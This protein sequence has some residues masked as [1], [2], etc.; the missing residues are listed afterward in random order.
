MLSN[1][2]RLLLALEKVKKRPSITDPQLAGAVEEAGALICAG[3][4]EEVIKTAD[5]GRHEDT[6]AQI[7]SAGSYLAVAFK[8]IESLT[9][10]YRDKSSQQSLRDACKYFH[11]AAHGFRDLGNIN[12]AADAYFRAGV[13]GSLVEEKT[14]SEREANLA[15]RS[16]ARAKICYQEIGIVEKSDQMHVLEWSA[17]SMDFQGVR[18]AL[19]GLWDVTSLYGTSLKRWICSMTLMLFAFTVLY[20][21][22]YYF[23]FLTADGVEWTPF[24]SSFYFALVTTTTVG[25]GDIGPQGPVGQISVVFNILLGYVL[26]A[27]GTTILGRKVLAR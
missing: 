15:V 22:L 13:A 20:E 24:V 3:G 1:T 4:E 17:R 8:S 25:Y 14:E 7:L 21:S 26:F 9:A 10:D 2:D 16:L 11:Y 23:E 5:R 6:K 12:R 27:I 19:L 18:W